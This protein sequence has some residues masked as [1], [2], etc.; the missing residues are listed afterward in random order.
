[1]PVYLNCHGSSL[2]CIPAGL[3]AVRDAQG[4]VTEGWEREEQGGTKA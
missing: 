4:I 2:S 3:E 1:M